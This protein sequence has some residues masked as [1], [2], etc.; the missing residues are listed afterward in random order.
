[1]FSKKIGIDL[2][3]A[4]FRVCSSLNK[5]IF[6]E[7][8]ILI[9]NPVS[10]EV[11]FKGDKAFEI[12][13]KEGS[14]L[15]P[16]RPV[17]N[18]ILQETLY[19]KELLQD[20]VN[21]ILGRNRLIRPEF[22]VSIPLRLRESDKNSITVLLEELGARSTSMLVPEVILSAIGLKLPIHR[23]TGLAIV[24]L[25]AGTTETAVLSLGGV[26]LG[27]SF[28]FGG[29]DLD[30]LIIEYFRSLN[31]EIGKKT[32][33]NLKFLFGSAEVIDINAFNEVKGKDLVT[34]KIV[35]FSFKIDQ[36]RNALK[37]GLIRIAES[38]KKVL[39]QL[40]PELASD[41]MDNGVILTGG[42]S[43]LKN[44]HFFLADYLNVPVFKIEER[45]ENSCILGIQYII[46]NSDILNKNYYIK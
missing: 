44:L 10:D 38:I 29:E 37:P 41:I 2:G 39:E 3:T 26:V 17:K 25:G 34:G 19:Q 40:P 6:S 24:N 28:A 8:N 11:V 12:F 22:I 35:S 9:I 27:D 20:S 32:A 16:I 4:N 42:G 45:P 30:Q 23:S 46:N 7:K 5:V 31:L 14:E 13:G 15:K 36:I 43:R 18:G 1:M 33:E 21:Q